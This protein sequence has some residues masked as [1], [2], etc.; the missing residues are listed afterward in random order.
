[1]GSKRRRGRPA[2]VERVAR[3]R[4]LSVEDNKNDSGG[5]DEGDKTDILDDK[6]PS[7][8]LPSPSGTT[9]LDDVFE[10]GP[11][12]KKNK[13]AETGH[14][15]A[16]NPSLFECLKYN[17]KSIIQAVK[18]WVE[19]YEKDPKSALSELLTMLFEACG[20]KYQ[21]S[22]G[23]LD[24]IDVDDVVIALVNLAK[25]GEA[26]DY[27]NPRQNDIKQKEITAKRKPKQKEFKNFKENLVCFWDNL[28]L[29]CQ[30][31]PLFDQ[32]LFE[33]CM[34]YV[35]ALSCTPPR[36][37]RRVATLVGLQLVSSFIT[38]AKTL[39]GQRETTQRQ[40]NAEK[41]KRKDGPRVESLEKRLSS[42]H[43][44]ITMTEEMMRKIFTGL[45]MH[46]YRDVDPDIRMS[47]IRYIGSWIVSYPSLFLQDLYLKYL[48]WTLNDKSAGVRKT[49]VL[50]LQTLYEVDDN[51]PSL[52]LFTERFSNRMVELADDIDVSVAVSAIGLLK[53]LLRH[54]LLS[55]DELGPLYDLLIDEEPVI[56]RAVGEL[57][58]DHLIAQKFSSSHTVSNGEGA[59]SSEIH[60]GRMLQILREFSSD[61][62]LST[63][64]I[65][66][67][68]DDMSSM[69]DWKCIIS[70]LLDE[71]PLIELTDTDATSL[72]RVLCASVKKAT[73]E[74]IVPANDNRKIHHTK[75]Q[76]EE[77]ENSRHEITIAL[78]KSYPQLLRKFIAD[79]T[80]VSSLCEIILYLKLELYSLKRQEPNFCSTLQLIKEAFFKHGE[81]EILRSGIKALDFCARESQADLQDFAQNKFKELEDES[82][83]KLTSVFSQVEVADDDYSLLVSLRRLY[84]LQCKKFPLNESLFEDMVGLLKKYNDLGDEVVSLLLLNMYL[85]ILWARKSLD[86]ENP[87]EALISS[88]L[89]KRTT[90]LEQLEHFLDT[91]LKS[92]EEGRTRGPLSSRVCIILAEIWCLFSKAKLAPSKL[93][94]LGFYPDI[95]ILKKFWRL[96]EQQFSISDDTE[97]EDV[98]EEYVDVTKLR[99][100]VM[101]AAA[102]LVTHDIVPKDFLGSEIIAHY[103]MHGKSIEDT[104]KHLITVLKKS[105]ADDIPNLFLGALKRAFQR[106]VNE[107]SRSDDESLAAKSIAE[108]KE[109]AS[110][111]S[112]T[113]IGAARNIHRLHILKIVN[114]G[115]VFAF[116]D[117]P[118]HLPFLEG[119]VL[120]FVSR[121]PASDVNDTIKDVKKRAEKFNP[122]EDPSGWRPYDKF[123]EF[124]R[125]KC[126]KN[127]GFQGEKEVHVSRRRGRPRKARNISGKKLFEGKDSS[128]EEE[129]ISE[130]E[131][132]EEEEEQ[133]EE[134]REPTLRE[135][136]GLKSIKLGSLMKL[137]RGE[138]QE[139]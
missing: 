36:V 35:I 134:E 54:Q 128:D 121:L 71:N 111:L 61:P 37:F 80:K 136:L 25:D 73:G 118:K 119:A 137:K 123:I 110:R 114:D 89:A 18:Q 127:E 103:V 88:L 120:H 53:Q 66:D 60:L 41:K 67:V 93:H 16:A 116:T 133:E 78:I 69:K 44:K 99:D 19:G 39:G 100:S 70:M 90:L 46:R 129:S 75:A 109:L 130:S 85:H 125:E 57:V 131:G 74:K 79:K 55:D 113:F 95:A 42:T 62:I 76:R 112:A 13:P 49:S 105:A 101:T 50:A 108:C 30:N 86:T 10:I 38:V 28:V 135:S 33:K 7:K 91:L 107:I 2:K 115:I 14:D 9:L 20:V 104:I 3:D 8:P 26:E 139:A 47:C 11:K 82:L 6:S 51:V 126:S 4:E 122:E 83:L 138:Q 77:F 98:N 92:W 40:L 24:E 12:R 72:V 43:G 32:L 106:H 1:M 117:V 64:V 102:K 58:Y 124:L 56:R 96:S 84:M 31:G 59:E 22:E 68:W 52:G 5:D 63:Y 27:C 21:F 65:D 34:D 17:G 87:A 23:S 45:F 29:E 94:A 81:I 97:D 132:E 48:G 15:G